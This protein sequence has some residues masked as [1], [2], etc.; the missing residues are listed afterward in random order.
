MR[1]ATFNLLHG[2]S[3]RDGLVDADR[4][5]NAVQTL[6]ADVLGLQ[7]VDRAQ[8]RSGELDLAG[9]AAAA[10]GAGDWRFQPALVGTP[11]EQ[12]RAATANDLA[13]TEPSYGVALV[14]R[15]PVRCWRAVPLAAARMRSPVVIPGSHRVLWLHDEPRVGLAAV[16][17]APTGPMTVA[18]THLSFVPGWN[19]VQLRR[20]VSALRDLPEPQ[21]LLGDLNL[22]GP[23]PRL[24]S[25]WQGLSQAR[26]YPADKPSVQ[27][28]HVLGHGTLPAVLGVETRQLGL[29]DHRAVVVELSDGPGGLPGS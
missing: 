17:E 28:D 27:I 9:L 12:W 10:M 6:R 4:L 24:L 2:R 15:L 21:L 13:T 25:R 18:T 14:S 8:P 3:L 5:T 7:E 1:V 26:T 11:G 16:I 22:P 29:S 23:L 19:V 20:L